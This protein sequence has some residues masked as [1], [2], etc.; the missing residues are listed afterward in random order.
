VA[1]QEKKFKNE[2]RLAKILMLP[3]LGLKLHECGI[4]AQKTRLPKNT[5]IMHEVKGGKKA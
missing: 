4:C 1:R 5:K 3:Y 2:G